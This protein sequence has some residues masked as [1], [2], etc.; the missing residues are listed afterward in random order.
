MATYRIY[1][2]TASFIR[3]RHDFTAEGDAAA[4]VVAGLL[5]EA[6]SDLCNL[7]ELW[8]GGKMVFPAAD[9]MAIATAT[10]AMLTTVRQE[11]V[12]SHEELIRDSSWTI[13]ESKRLLTRIRQLTDEGVLRRDAQEDR[14]RQRRLRMTAGELRAAAEQMAN[15]VKQ[16]CYRRLAENYEGLANDG[17]RKPE[18]PDRDC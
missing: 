6:C 8:Q 16:R 11:A 3:G 17:W 12:R 14:G 18:G 1:F 9:P 2:R 7:F 5:Y 15:P 13:A 10:S 4:M